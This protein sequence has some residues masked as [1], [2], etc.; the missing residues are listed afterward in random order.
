VSKYHYKG[1]GKGLLVMSDDGKRL[2]VGP[3][4]KLS[5]SV[6]DC[7]NESAR[8]VRTGLSTWRTLCAEHSHEV[9]G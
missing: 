2:D 1:N 3:L 9:D 5:C 6:K 7:P 8:L 4:A